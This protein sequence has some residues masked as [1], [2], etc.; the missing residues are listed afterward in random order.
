MKELTIGHF[1]I[2]RTDR[3]GHVDYY[4]NAKSVNKISGWTY[5]QQNARVFTGK[6]VDYA[7]GRIRDVASKEEWDKSYYGPYFFDIIPVIIKG[8]EL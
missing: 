1:I 4:M 7:L 2:K 6:A 3:T 8:V 5:N